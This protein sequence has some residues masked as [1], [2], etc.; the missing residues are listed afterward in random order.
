MEDESS[1]ATSE[2]SGDSEADSIP[3]T[4]STTFEFDDAD[5]DAESSSGG[6]NEKNDADQRDE[7]W[8]SWRSWLV[9][10]AS[11][12]EHMEYD[13]EQREDGLLTQNIEENGSMPRVEKESMVAEERESNRLFWE[14]CLADGYP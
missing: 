10:Y 7:R 13:D 9:E 3:I 4:P 14:A 5:D 6:S 1:P 12:S 8:M 2:F 11:Q